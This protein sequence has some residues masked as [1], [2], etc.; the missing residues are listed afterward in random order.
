M[1]SELRQKINLLLLSNHQTDQV[2][3]ICSCLFRFFGIIFIYFPGFENI[4]SSRPSIA[5][6][7]ERR[8]VEYND[9]EILRS[10]VR[11][12]FE[13]LVFLFFFIKI[14]PY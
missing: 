3:T 8:T 11:I 14:T 10:L 4:F 1:F 9:I 13:G 5:Q 7:A 6:L 2:Y 12:R